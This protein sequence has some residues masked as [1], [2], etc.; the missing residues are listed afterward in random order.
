[1][2]TRVIIFALTL[3]CFF[4]ASMNVVIAQYS[5]TFLDPND[6]V[7]KQEYSEIDVNITENVTNKPYI[8]IRELVCS[9][10][11]RKVTLELT[12]GDSI[13]DLGD[14]R[15]LDEEYLEQLDET[16]D[17]DELME[18]FSQTTVS[19]SIDLFS[20]DNEYVIMYVNK[21]V[22]IFDG[23]FNSL[24]ASPPVVSDNTLTI[25]FNLPS[26]K[27]NLTG[28]AANTNEGGILGLSDI[29]YYDDMPIT[30]CNDEAPVGGDDNNGDENKDGSESGLTVF[31]ALIVVFVI[32]GIAVVVY[33]IRR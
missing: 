24:E 26:S 4:I 9:R 17:Y 31:I 3:C 10:N 22:L 15:L 21:N 1:M 18:L 7:I 5:E 19:Y 32:A 33:L 14:I 12:V 30:E 11:Y 29:N 16:M 27:E 6:D 28:I 23:D 25:S 2:K 8:D 20:S 13:K